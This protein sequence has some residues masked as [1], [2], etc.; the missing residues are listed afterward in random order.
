M[1]VKE[2][3]LRATYQ[4]GYDREIDNWK[5]ID[6]HIIPDIFTDNTEVDFYC[7]NGISVYLL[8]IR[9]N[10]KPDKEKY[11]SEPPDENT[12]IIYLIAEINIDKIDDNLICKLL[13]KFDL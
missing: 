5:I 4:G 7:C 10:C 3:E 1:T 6:I 11:I 8:R 13:N 12:N 9:P 2:F